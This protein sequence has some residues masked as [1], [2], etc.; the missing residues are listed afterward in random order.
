[1]AEVGA[2]GGKE[3]GRG[4]EGGEKQTNSVT[5]AWRVCFGG[6]KQNPATRVC[7]GSEKQTPEGEGLGIG[8]GG[9]R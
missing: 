8:G 3:G 6:Q 5:R 4:E 9:G 2:K 7:F 1:M